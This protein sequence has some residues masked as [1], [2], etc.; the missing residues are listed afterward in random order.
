MQNQRVKTLLS[1]HGQDFFSRI[2]KIGFQRTTDLYF[3]GDRQAHLA[4]LMRKGWYC[5]DSGLTY[6]EP[7]VFSDPGNHPSHRSLTAQWI[8]DVEAKLG[9]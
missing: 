6:A 4:W 2:G 7:G 1:R 8:D 9:G 5:V 3:G